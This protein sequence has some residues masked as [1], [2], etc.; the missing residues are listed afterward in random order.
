[1]NLVIN[2]WEDNSSEQYMQRGCL[3]H[4]AGP[5]LRSDDGSDFSVKRE[6]ILETLEFEHEL[7]AKEFI[8][9]LQNGELKGKIIPF[10][11]GWEYE[12]LLDD[13]IGKVE[14]SFQEIPDPEP[15]IL[16]SIKCL[17]DVLS[18]L[19]N[20]G[21][22]LIDE[23]TSKLGPSVRVRDEHH[24]F[25]FGFVPDSAIKMLGGENSD[26][27]KLK[28]QSSSGYFGTDAKIAG[29]RYIGIHGAHLAFRVLFA[30][31]ISL[32]CKGTLLSELDLDETVSNKGIPEESLLVT[33]WDCLFPQLEKW[34]ILPFRFRRHVQLTAR[35]TDLGN[36]SW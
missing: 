28:V 35:D 7:L 32:G 12:A 2:N 36:L 6:K 11:N 29:Q 4:R 34:Q 20:G 10:E 27:G 26:N 24:G 8:T 23:I 19:P 33:Q 14:Y 31:M 22:V 1:M 9:K 30:R 21:R 15:V 3:V 17:K 16:D 18:V 13:K 25:T 5:F